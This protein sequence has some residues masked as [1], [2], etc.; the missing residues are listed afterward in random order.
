MFWNTDWIIFAFQS[1]GILC[2]LHDEVKLLLKCVRRHQPPSSTRPETHIWE[3]QQQWGN[4]VATCVNSLG[5][6]FEGHQVE[7]LGV[8]CGH[9]PLSRDLP[10]CNKSMYLF[11][12]SE[13]HMRCRSNRRKGEET[14]D[15]GRIRALVPIREFSQS[16]GVP[17]ITAK[18]LFRGSKE[19]LLLLMFPRLKVTSAS[20]PACLLLFVQRSTEGR[21]IEGNGDVT[22]VI[23]TVL[24]GALYLTRHHRGQASVSACTLPGGA[25]ACQS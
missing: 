15:P 24:R 21:D 22:I 9:S 8:I 17:R 13:I 25:A 11:L 6:M 2:P 5:H 12:H 19:H 23:I 1:V 16:N 18:R 7:F 3:H 4:N 14:P 10:C 20:L